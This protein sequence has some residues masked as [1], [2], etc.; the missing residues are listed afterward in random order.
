MQVALFY[1]ITPTEA[2]GVI[3]VW[4][5]SLRRKCQ[6]SSNHRWQLRSLARPTQSS[7]AMRIA[8]AHY[9]ATLFIA[10]RAGAQSERQRHTVNVLADLS[11][12]IGSYP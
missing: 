10:R 8:G 2:Y 12:L 1:A 3:N 9:R 4:S 6:P 7:L 5:K 11:A